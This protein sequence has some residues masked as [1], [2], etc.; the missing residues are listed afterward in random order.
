MTPFLCLLAWLVASM[1]GAGFI[2]WTC[3]SPRAVCP[4]RG[5]EH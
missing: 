4:K 1:A 2:V 3:E 5:R